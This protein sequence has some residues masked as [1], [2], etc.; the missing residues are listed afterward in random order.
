M[1]PAFV[2]TVHPVI[3]VEPAVHGELEVIAWR[4]ELK[5]K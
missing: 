5:K 1:L 4:E 2:F 3:T